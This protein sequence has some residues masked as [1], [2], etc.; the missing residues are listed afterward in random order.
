MSGFH[1]AFY[2]IFAGAIASVLVAAIAF[3]RTSQP[4]PEWALESA[5]SIAGGLAVETGLKLR[6]YDDEVPTG[7][8]RCQTTNDVVSWGFRPCGYGGI[9]GAKQ[10]AGSGQHPGYCLLRAACFVRI[11]E[12]A[13]FG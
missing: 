4:E 6:R 10:A 1:D 8:Q 5:G 13:E 7:L 12:S 11:L 3:P 2:V 9:D